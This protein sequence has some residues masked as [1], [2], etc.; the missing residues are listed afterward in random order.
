[1]APVS[2][3]YSSLTGN[4]DGFVNEGSGQTF[5]GVNIDFDYP[6]FEH[7]GEGPLALDHPHAFR[8]D[9]SYTT[10][11]G[12]LVG[13][14]GWALSGA[15][16]NRMGYFNGGYGSTSCREGRR[17]GWRR[18]GR[19]NLTLGYQFAVGPTIV[20]AQAYAFNIFNNQI[21]TQR[22]TAWTVERPEGYPDTLYDPNVPR[23]TPTTARSR[24]AKRR[25][26]SRAA[27]KVSFC[28]RSAA[29]DSF[30]EESPIAPDRTRAARRIPWRGPPRI[31]KN[32]HEPHPGN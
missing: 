10:P 8:L 26:S 29:V 4:Y 13:L 18:S 9:A 30:S 27:M 25:D 7:N 14:Q 2:Y 16:L 24:R 23:T 6:Q 1:M 22:D 28:R 11:F 3:I 21:E 5:P 12:V 32:H 17:D 31:E 20:T 19:R 15:P